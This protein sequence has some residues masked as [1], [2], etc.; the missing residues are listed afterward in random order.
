MLA[1][2]VV[3][4]AAVVF[5]LGLDGF[6]QPAAAEPAKPFRV[7]YCTVSGVLELCTEIHG[8]TRENETPSG[9]RQ[10]HVVE[11]TCYTWTNIHTD[12]VVEQDCFRDNFVTIFSNDGT[13]VY[14]TNQKDDYE[15][16][17]DGTTYECTHRYN[18]T[19]ANG[20][21]RHYDDQLECNPPLPN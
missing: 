6:T 21:R 11:K 5:L 20:E 1:R 13:Q 16:T 10:L 14:H 2:F 17:L 18:I 15:I 8:V 9:N 19:Y 12:E 3:L 4:A 7:G